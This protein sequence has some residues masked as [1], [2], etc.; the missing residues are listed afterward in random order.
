[1]INLNHYC[2]LKFFLKEK[3]VSFATRNDNTNIYDNLA[4]DTE[5]IGVS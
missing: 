1:M 3:G 5:R 4:P 2:S